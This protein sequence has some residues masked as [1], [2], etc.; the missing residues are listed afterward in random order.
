MKNYNTL[1]YVYSFLVLVSSFGCLVAFPILPAGD[2]WGGIGP[3]DTFSIQLL[4]PDKQSFFWRPLDKIFRYVFIHGGDLWKFH[5]FVLCGHVLT[6]VV[7]FNTLQKLNRSTSFNFILT[8]FFGIT[9]SITAAIWS[10]DSITQVYCTLFGLLAARLHLANVMRYNLLSYL[11]I[12]VAIFWKES[13]LGW[14]FLVPFLGYLQKINSIHINDNLREL[15]KKIAVSVLLVCSYLMLR[16]ALNE[17]NIAGANSER[18]SINYSLLTLAKNTLMLLGASIVPVDTLEIMSEKKYTNSVLAIAAWLVF[19]TSACKI[20]L[21]PRFVNGNFLTV[22]FAAAALF[23]MLAPHIILSNVSEMYVYTILA[24]LILLLS[25]LTD[26]VLSIKS[27]YVRLLGAAFLIIC[28][29]VNVSYNKWKHM[30]DTGLRASAIGSAIAEQSNIK[31][32][33]S[34]CIL[35]GF[36]HSVLPNGASPYSVFFMTTEIASD[37]GRSF[38]GSTDWSIR[39]IF[40]FA[41]VEENCSVDTIEIWSIEGGNITVSKM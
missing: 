20:K 5:S 41:D 3:I 30:Y 4:L 7:L 33:E 38:L 8:V 35:N 28:A 36:E 23:C 12:I 9:P 39:P 40:N 26:G 15:F 32:G 10:F 37:Y 14:A 25:G 1:V 11:L 2:D 16:F 21:S 19:L 13:G 34:V 22:V 24:A 6:V 31:S 27:S 29:C 17:G 18:Y